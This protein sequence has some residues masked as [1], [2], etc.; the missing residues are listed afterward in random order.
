ML[1]KADTHVH[2]YYSGTTH[3]KALRFPES[4]TSPEE[5]VDAARRNGMSVV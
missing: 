2:T 1:S 4:V 5:Q 3:Y